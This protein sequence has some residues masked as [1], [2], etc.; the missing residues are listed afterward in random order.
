MKT[1]LNCKKPFLGLLIAILFLTSSDIISQVKKSADLKD[2]KFIIEKTDNGVKMKS[3]AGCAWIDLT[4]SL[5]FYSAQAV[6]EYG[7]TKLD[8]VSEVVD[9]NLADFLFTITKTDKGFIL[10]GIKGTAWTE[11]TFSNSKNVKQMINQFGIS[12]TY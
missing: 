9:N 1:T 3:S 10:N 11:L 4:F 8:N 2:F 6:D 7:M 5:D 12:S